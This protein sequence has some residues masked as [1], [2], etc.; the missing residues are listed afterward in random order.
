M[1]KRLFETGQIGNDE[2][3]KLLEQSDESIGRYR[4]IYA[5]STGEP[6]DRIAVDNLAE[7]SVNAYEVG[8]I[9]FEKL[10]YLLDICGLKPEDVG[11][12]KNYGTQFPS[13][14]ELDRI[15]EED[16]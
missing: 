15:M 13:D 2:R 5:F 14:E 12:K 10:E 11:I 1:V 7:L 8:L 16:E 4:K 3:K 6:D 9:T